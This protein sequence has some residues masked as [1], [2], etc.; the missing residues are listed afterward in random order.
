L[1]YPPYQTQRFYQIH[2][3]FILLCC[4]IKLAYQNLA[5]AKFGNASQIW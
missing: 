4:Q 3:I 2:S 5:L 1:L